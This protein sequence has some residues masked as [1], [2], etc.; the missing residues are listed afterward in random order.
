MSW[1]A[2][3]GVTAVSGGAAKVFVPWTVWSPVSSTASPLATAETS[4][5]VRTTGPVR[6]LT[7]VTGEPSTAR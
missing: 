7:E 2:V 1:S 6:P 4:A 5:A 3:V